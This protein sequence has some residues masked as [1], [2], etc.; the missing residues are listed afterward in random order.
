MAKAITLND[1]DRRQWVQNDE[2]LYT[3]WR[4]S[5]IGLYRFVRENRAE[6]TVVILAALNREPAR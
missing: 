3:W 4:Q 2:G 5:G 1:E 6:L